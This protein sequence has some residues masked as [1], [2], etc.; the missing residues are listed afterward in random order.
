MIKKILITTMIVSSLVLG[1][2]FGELKRAEISK[3]PLNANEVPLTNNP[4]EYEFQTLN[5]KKTAL[6]L[7]N[8]LINVINFWATWCPPCKKEI[9][10]F[11][12]KFQLE[13]SKGIGVIGV[14]MDEKEQILDFLARQSIDYPI[15]FGQERV[16]E[17]MDYYGNSFGVL[18]FTVITDENGKY[19][20]SVVGEVSDRRL[21][22]VI[23]DARILIE[24]KR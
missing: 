1:Y 15:F 10:V 4:V 3:K 23:A 8:N 2:F 21:S 11:N 9:P 16:S 7:Q 18:P 19:L 22:E 6:P 24:K 13:F 14:A 12:E 5:S 20:T 17:L